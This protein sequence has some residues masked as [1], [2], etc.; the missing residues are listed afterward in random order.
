MVL[1]VDVYMELAPVPTSAVVLLSL[2][3]SHVSWGARK[4]SRN[5]R[6]S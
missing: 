3:P 1:F 2:I 5:N 6:Q 4:S